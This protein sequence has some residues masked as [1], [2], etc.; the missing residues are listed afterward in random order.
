MNHLS[1]EELFHQIII[2]EGE[3]QQGFTPT[4]DSGVRG[5]VIK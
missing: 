5:E 1:D 4:F 2:G 3:T